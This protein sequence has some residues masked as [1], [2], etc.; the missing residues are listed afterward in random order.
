MFSIVSFEPV[1]TEAVCH[2]HK[3][4]HIVNLSLWVHMILH[5]VLFEPV[6]TQDVSHSHFC[7]CEY[8][9]CLI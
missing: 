7:D 1:C 6:G 2:S 8:T 4:F 5:L 9:I 3:M